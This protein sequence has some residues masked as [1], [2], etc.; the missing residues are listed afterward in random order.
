MSDAANALD[1]A[2]LATDALFT[3]TLQRVSFQPGI[4]LGSDALTTEQADHVR[5]L[6]R[7][8]RWLNGPGTV[9]GLRVDVQSPAA[10]ATGDSV[11]INVG[12]GYAID[13]L[14]R[15]VMV[16]QSYSISLRDWLIAQNGVSTALSQYYV[17][18]VL[19][20]RLT[21]RAQTLESQLQP[22]VAELFDAG[23]DPVVAARIDDGFA[24]EISGD[25]NMTGEHTP[26]ARASQI[27]DWSPD[28]TAP[29]AAG[30]TTATPTPT[31]TPAPTPAPVPTPTPTP[32]PPPILSSAP[33]PTPAPVA[34][35]ARERAMLAAASSNGAILQA[36]NLQS[37]LLMRPF[38]TYDD[39]PG[40][41]DRFA[42]AS[43]LLLASIQVTLAS[44]SAAPSSASVAINNLVRPFVPNILLSALALP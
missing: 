28:H 2:E 40:A 26:D 10:G 41:Q 18:N 15:E 3:D 25:P 19:Y 30:P 38:P 34:L 17:N 23:L 1:V 16:G 20:L 14:G 29:P 43:R 36:L 42:E 22:V 24:L 27:V 32:T 8:L 39:S 35:T 9:F 33:T 4:L 11:R 13:G 21:V 37:W 44:Q 7:I 31:P 12:P 5:R 6:N